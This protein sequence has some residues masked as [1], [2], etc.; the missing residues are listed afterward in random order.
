MTDLLDLAALEADDPEL[1]PE[2]VN[3]EARFSIR[4]RAEA[5]A[6][7]FSRVVSV[8]PAK[9][10]LPG[11]SFA[12]LE[13]VPATR[14][15]VAHVR[16][17][18][19]DGDHIVS[20][21]G[22][23]VAV[24]V[25]GIVQVPAKR[26]ADILK[27]APTATVAIE[28]IGN[29]ARIQSGRA[30]WT[31]QLP[32]GDTT[33]VLV[34]VS[35]IELAPVPRVPFLEALVVARR[36][37]STSDARMSLT[38]IMLRG[39]MITGCDG[40]RLHRHEAEGIGWADVAIPVKAA[41]EAIRALRSTDDEMFEFGYDDGYIVFQIGSDSIVSRRLSVPFPDVE[42]LVL[43]PAFSNQEILTVETQALLD[44][45]KRVRVNADPDS[46]TVFLGLVPGKRGADGL[47]TW[48]LAVRA[49]DRVGNAS[50]EG[51]PCQ[52]TGGQRKVDLAFNHKYLTDLLISY[53]EDMAI[54][55]VGEDVK[56]SRSPI[57]LEDRTVG[58]VGVV[59][60]VAVVW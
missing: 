49:R 55:K 43:G 8:V 3:V 36:A 44:A 24:S 39:G 23:G 22:Q 53:S 7:V 60:Q 10:T 59:Q 12:V 31:V 26:V 11:T 40:G 9:E 29:E 52:W 32:V 15:E 16:L 20:V 17:T 37:A 48:A 47:L 19:T 56:S 4:A 18:G 28:V 50:Q 33:G 2:I 57:L 41:D 13:A 51:L 34:D 21:V 45:I 1:V 35:G 14:Q 38:Q 46:A 54:I 30:R 42:S 25:P 5:L 27:L 6:D 58:F